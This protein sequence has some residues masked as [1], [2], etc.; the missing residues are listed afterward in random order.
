MQTVIETERLI[1]REL[2]PTDDEAMFEMDSNPEV[3]VFLGNKPAESIEETRAT[4]QNVRQQYIERGIGRWAMVEK[5]SGSFVGWTG[6]KLNKETINNHIDFYETGYRLAQKHWNKGYATESTK[7]AL[8]YAFEQL[9]AKE[10]CG[11]TNVENLKSRKVLEKCGLIFIETFVWHRWN[12]LPCNWYKI[13]R[14][15]WEI[16]NGN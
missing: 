6:L 16:Q 15:E 2:M 10:V 1:L 13:T 3:H 5:S 4:I 8:K 11:I 12:E 14:Q 7:A 9:N